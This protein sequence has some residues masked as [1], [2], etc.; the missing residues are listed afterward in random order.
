MPSF[1]NDLA[2]RD[3]KALV[4]KHP[5]LIVVDPSKLNSAETL[6]L[7]QQLS[8]AGARM[9]MAK[10]SLI[11]RALPAAAAAMVEGR[12]PIALVSAPDMLTAAKILA[13]LAK[14]EKLALKGGL[15]DG[16][17]IDTATVKKLASL[18]S[19]Q[20]LRGMLVNVLAAPLVGLAR[21]VAEIEKKLKP[22]A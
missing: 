16:K 2:L 22:A 15:M 12:T 19:Q 9:K 20:V 13:E 10:V 11:K 4:A 7:R 8:G 1:L 17:V 21:V 3:I 6:K 14:D 18:P 5:S